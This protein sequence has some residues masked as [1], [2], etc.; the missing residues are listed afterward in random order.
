MEVGKLR[1]ST[2]PIFYFIIDPDTPDAPNA[3]SLKNYF[4]TTTVDSYVEAFN[5]LCRSLCSP[6][7]DPQLRRWH[8]LYCKI[9]GPITF[10]AFVRNVQSLPKNCFSLDLSEEAARDRLTVKK[11]NS[12]EKRKVQ[13][14]SLLVYPQRDD[15]NAEV[16]LHRLKAELAQA[17]GALRIEKE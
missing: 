9:F 2:T 3:S 13:E 14:T 12:P 4:V 5:F 10:D 6:A 1:S 7:T 11:I 15:D 8:N 17:E 16:E